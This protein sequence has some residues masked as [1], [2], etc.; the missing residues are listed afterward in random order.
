M[1]AMDDLHTFTFCRDDWNRIIQALRNEAYYL[2]Q[3][4]N[5]AQMKG[6]RDYSQVLWEESHY[7]NALSNDIDFS[8]PS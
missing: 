2:T 7:H 5:R 3:E 4:S 8:I 6:A 1:K